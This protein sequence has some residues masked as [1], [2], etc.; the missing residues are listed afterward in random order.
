MVL[1]ALLLLVYLIKR[2]IKNNNVIAYWL[3]KYTKLLLILTLST[4]SSPSHRAAISHIL[5][6]YYP[7][8][9][10]IIIPDLGTDV[11]V[12]TVR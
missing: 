7:L 10:S 5:R 12:Y 3:L 2:I 8:P 9:C 11:G 6:T 4:F 1:I